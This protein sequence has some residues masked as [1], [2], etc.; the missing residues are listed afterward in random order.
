MEK[1]CPC[2]GETV[3]FGKVLSWVKCHHCG[4]ELRSN[5]KNNVEFK[6]ACPTCGNVLNV[7]A[8]ES[9]HTCTKCGTAYSVNDLLPYRGMSSKNER[10]IIFYRGNDD[11]VIA[12]KHGEENFISGSKLI[13][14]E[15]QEA[16]FVKDGKVLDTFNA[17]QNGHLLDTDRSIAFSKAAPHIASIN[18]YYSTQV[19]FIRMTP[20]L[21]QPWGLGGVEYE[22]HELKLPMKIGVNGVLD[23]K[24]GNSRLLKEKLIGTRNCLTVGTLFTPSLE[25]EERQNITSYR[26]ILLHEIQSSLS[27]MLS[28]EIKDHGYCFK[29]FDGMRENFADKAKAL[30]SSKFEDLGLELT[31]FTVAQINCTTMNN[32]KAWDAYN[33]LYTGNFDTRV[34]INNEKNAQALA[35]VHNEGEVQAIQHE[36]N[37]ETLKNTAKN[38]QEFMEGISR[39]IVDRL[40][41]LSDAEIFSQYKDV[42]KSLLATTEVISRNNALGKAASGSTNAGKGSVIGD[43]IGALSGFEAADQ[44]IKGAGNI[45]ATNNICPGSMANQQSGWTCTCGHKNAKSNS[46]CEN[47][48]KKTPSNEAKKCPNCGTI[49]TGAFCGQCGTKLI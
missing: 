8:S 42:L 40:K 6:C 45:E 5:E 35:G 24:V 22:D 10:S 7:D 2:C 47:C 37:I 17:K 49:G 41:G 14:D 44:L 48:G 46:F 1:I 12:W 34:A 16:L 11:T 19:Y 29:D 33:R 32:E 18:G 26:T 15:S 13:V 43:A 38:D 30:L 4:H 23:F 9:T 36:I 3:R 31:G 27:A 28:N 20:F 25:E 39:I 21:A